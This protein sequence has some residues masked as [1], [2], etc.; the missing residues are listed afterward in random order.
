[1]WLVRANVC[2]NLSQAAHKWRDSLSPPPPQSAR[3]VKD[4][5]KFLI[6]AP[7]RNTDWPVGWLR[8]RWQQ[9]LIGLRLEQ[10]GTQTKVLRT[11]KFNIIY[12][13]LFI[14]HLFSLLQIR[15]PGSD[16]WC[17][18]LIF[19]QHCRSQLKLGAMIGGAGITKESTHWCKQCNTLVQASQKCATLYCKQ[20][21]ILKHCT[22]SEGMH[23]CK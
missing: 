19:L 16:R 11:K 14:Y 20:H 7:T 18:S 15:R 12:I 1:M 13:I 21:K 8:G 4:P 3:A 23:Y 6:L 2:E 10:S 5:L 17:A 9:G 22:L